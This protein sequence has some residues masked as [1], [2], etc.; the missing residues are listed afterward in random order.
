[1]VL[2]LVLLAVVGGFANPQDKEQ[3]AVSWRWFGR[4][5]I[6]GSGPILAQYD[7]SNVELEIMVSGVKAVA[8]VLS[9]NG[10]QY[11]IHVDNVI[12]G[13]LNTTN[14]LEHPYSLV[15]GL[16]LS[17]HRILMRKRT[18]AL[19]GLVSF[20]GVKVSLADGQVAFF[21]SP[22]SQVYNTPP[23]APERRIEFVGASVNCGYGIEGTVPCRASASTEN[24]LVAYGALIAAGLKAELHSECWS[25]KG[26]VRNYGDKNITSKDPF[27]TYWPRAVANMPQAL[28]NFSHWVPHAV[29]IN[30]GVNDYSTKPTPP[31]NIFISGYMSWLASIK[32]HY[33]IDGQ[34]PH[35]FLACGPLIA[36]PLCTYVKEV[37]TL[38]K[39]DRIHYLDLENILHYPNDFG[40]DGHPNILGHKKIAAVALPILKKILHW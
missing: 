21:Q 34:I 7:W 10:N 6:K 23:P 22:S 18:E 8:V 40:C 30:L 2:G 20:Y 16:S 39:S 4:V 24:G 38:E 15:T 25:G 12:V 14:A 5:H 28:W 27:P 3:A 29:V 33:R 17:S 11:D 32:L 31:E 13:R 19:Y 36:K 9:D 1:V 37:V 26:V 35:I